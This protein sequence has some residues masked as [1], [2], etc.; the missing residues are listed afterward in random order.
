MNHEAERTPSRSV[1]EDLILRRE[2][3]DARAELRSL[4]AT[5]PATGPYAVYLDRESRH[6]RTVLY[7]LEQRR[8]LVK[9]PDRP[10]RRKQG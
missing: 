8:N 3:D 5:Y 4:E 1:A 6:L 10:P 7:R 9:E 2:R